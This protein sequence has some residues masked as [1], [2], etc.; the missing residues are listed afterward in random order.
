MASLVVDGGVALHFLEQR[1]K[2]PVAPGLHRTDDGGVEHVDG[3]ASLLPAL[4]SGEM[5]QDLLQEFGVVLNHVP[6]DKDPNLVGFSQKRKSGYT[7]VL[8]EN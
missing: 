2:L 1:V 7:P 4:L 3:V 5:L 6:D 8:T